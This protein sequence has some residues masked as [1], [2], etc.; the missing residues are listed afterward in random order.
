MTKETGDIG[1]ELLK[2]WTKLRRDGWH[3][4]VGLGERVQSVCGRDVGFVEL[5]DQ[6]QRSNKVRGEEFGV[7]EEVSHRRLD[8]RVCSNLNAE[9]SHWFRHGFDE[10]DLSCRETHASVIMARSWTA[11]AD[12]V[13]RWPK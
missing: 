13:E 1:S 6:G 10:A 3:G 12:A 5:A 11:K 2:I 8:I 9:L 4:S 7:V